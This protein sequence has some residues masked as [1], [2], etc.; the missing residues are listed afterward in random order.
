[1]IRGQPMMR[2]HPT[3]RGRP[4]TMRGRPMMMRGQPMTTRGQPTTREWELSLQVHAFIF[5]PIMSGSSAWPWSR[6]PRFS[7][8]LSTC[9]SKSATMISFLF[10]CEKEQ[11]SLSLQLCVFIFKLIMSGRS[12]AWLSTGWRMTMHPFRERCVNFPIL[13]K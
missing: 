2:G 1:M 3:K 13:K 9:Q 5:K 12:S 8:W 7:T 6:S 10:E 4:T 11:P